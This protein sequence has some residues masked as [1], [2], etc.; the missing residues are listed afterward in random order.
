MQNSK[1]TTYPP[2][3]ARIS[4]KADSGLEDTP[5]VRLALSPSAHNALQ[6]VGIKTVGQIMDNWD[7]LTQMPA[8]VARGCVGTKKASLGAVKAKEIHACVFAFLCQNAKVKLSIDTEGC[9]R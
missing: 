4:W 5:I 6:R 7:R 3:Q 1:K 8:K 2:I 9:E